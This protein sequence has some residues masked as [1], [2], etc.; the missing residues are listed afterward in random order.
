[1]AIKHI[2]LKSGERLI[3]NVQE[4]I[5]EDKVVGY[6]F[7]KPCVVSVATPEMQP[8]KSGKEKMPID[9]SLYPWIPFG[10]DTQVP[11]ALDWVV[12]F[13]EPVDML[14]EMYQK[15]VLEISVDWNSGMNYSKNVDGDEN[16]ECKNCR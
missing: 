12:T 3:A 2:I 6:F 16:G 10:K 7:E 15:N 8:P 5:F 13:V 14:F 9:V 4:M 11:I 1:M